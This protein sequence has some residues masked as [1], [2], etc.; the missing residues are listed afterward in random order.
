MGATAAL[1]REMMV[2]VEGGEG[3]GK[4]GEERG[5][6]GTEEGGGTMGMEE[7]IGTRMAGP[8]DGVDASVGLDCDRV[9]AW[10]R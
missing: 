5:M 1:E 9:R 4:R 2:E 7:T 6:K 10:F 8:S 3:A